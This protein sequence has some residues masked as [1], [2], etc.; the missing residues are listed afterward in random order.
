MAD[1]ALSASDE[2]AVDDL[3]DSFGRLFRAGDMEGWAA[4]F[5]DRSDFI[6]WG[7]IWW[8]SRAENLAAHRAIPAAV[9]VQLPAY[10]YTTVKREALGAEIVLAHGRWDWPGFVADGAPPEDRAGLLTIVLRKGE[11][12]WRIRAVHNTRIGS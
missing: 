5:H 10:R 12:G 1:T 8:T 4:L 2:A 7:G 6:S 9:A 3:L 11:P